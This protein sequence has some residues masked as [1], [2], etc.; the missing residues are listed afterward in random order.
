MKAIDKVT[1]RQHSI[2]PVLGGYQVCIIP[3]VEWENANISNIC[4]FSNE[5]FNER[6]SLI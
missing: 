1:K 2:C 3:D 4:V 6:F 5:Q